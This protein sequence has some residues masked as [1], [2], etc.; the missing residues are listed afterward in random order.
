MPY[1]WTGT[2]SIIIIPFLHVPS[3]WSIVLIQSQKCKGIRVT[4]TILKKKKV[5]ELTSTR[6]KTKLQ[7]QDKMIL[8]KQLT[9]WMIEQK[10]KFRNWLSMYSQH[11]QLIFDKGTKAI[12]RKERL[13]YKCFWKNT[14]IVFKE[15]HQPLPD[16]TQQN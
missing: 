3:N 12:W 11:S 5:E 6:F 15:E 4:K 7:N 1:L 14:H 10:R 2:L 8:T 16:T 13:F 9:N